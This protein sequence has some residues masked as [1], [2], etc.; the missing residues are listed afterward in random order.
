MLRLLEAEGLS[1]FALAQVPFPSS[2]ADESEDLALLQARWLEFDSTTMTAFLTC[3]EKAQLSLLL[4]CATSAEMWDRLRDTY[5]LKSDMTIFRLET[6]LATL[7]LKG[8]QTLEDFISKIDHCSEQLRSCGQPV[9]DARLKI[10]LLKGCQRSMPTSGMLSMKM[11]TSPTWQ[12]ATEC[13]LILHFCQLKNLHR[14]RHWQPPP[15]K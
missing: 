2:A 7:T 4:P 11:S 12:H 5:L 13:G 6:E 10:T 3:V 1:P 8:S 14:R 9:T 15:P